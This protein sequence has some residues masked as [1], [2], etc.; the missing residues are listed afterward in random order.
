MKLLLD[1]HVLIWLAGA[2]DQIPQAVRKALIS[3]EQN[4]ASVASAW[5]YGMKRRRHPEVL[6]LPFLTLMKGLAEP[7]DLDF[8]C[9]TYAE[10]LPRLHGDPFDRILVAQALHH[11]LV[12]VTGDR[13]VRRYPVETL[14]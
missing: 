13:H 3:S 7:L 5:E 12:L 4:Y 9:H 11:G 14:W 1:T 8:A 6:P 10:T 2:P